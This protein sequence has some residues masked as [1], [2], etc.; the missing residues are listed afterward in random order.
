M[1]VWQNDGHR[2]DTAPFPPPPCTPRLLFDLH[3]ADK[4][5]EAVDK[6]SYA[7]DDAF[8]VFRAKPHGGDR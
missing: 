5:R 4:V 2:S 6:H 8:T 7:E 3:Y 1:S